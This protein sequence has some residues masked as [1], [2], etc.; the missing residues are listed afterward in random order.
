MDGHSVPSAL[1]ASRCYPGSTGRSSKRV[2]LRFLPGILPSRV[3]TV[4]LGP[5]LSPTVPLDQLGW[6]KRVSHTCRT[7]GIPRPEEP[8]RPRAI[9][10][11]YPVLPAHVCV[12]RNQLALPHSSLPHTLTTCPGSVLHRRQYFPLVSGTLADLLSRSCP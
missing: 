9:L 3:C 2:A 6:T 7:L 8:L 4:A 1:R 10:E 11:R 12:P 5:R